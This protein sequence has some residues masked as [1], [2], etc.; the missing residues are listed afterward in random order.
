[1]IFQKMVR[2]IPKNNTLTHKNI[3]KN[4]LTFHYISLNF[5]AK[6]RKLLR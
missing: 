5:I 1:M 2:N 3:M 4:I 6:N